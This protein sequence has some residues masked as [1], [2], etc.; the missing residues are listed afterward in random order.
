[1]SA[2]SFSRKRPRLQKGGASSSQPR[3][4]TASAYG[5]C[6]V[7]DRD[8]PLY[9]MNEHLDECFAEPSSEPASSSAAALLGMGF[10]AP[11]VEVA[12]HEAGN[13]TGAALENLLTTA[14]GA[15]AAAHAEAPTPTPQDVPTLQD[16][17]P[18]Q[19]AT[20]PAATIPSQGGGRLWTVGHSNRAQEALLTLLAQHEI[21]TLIDVRT[22]PLS[23]R[24]P[25]FNQHTLKGACESRGVRYEHH[26]QHLGGRFVAGG[27]EGNLSS[28]A[29]SRALAA[30]AKRCA[31]G[32]ERLA[33]MCSEASWHSCH[34]KALARELVR[35]HRCAVLHIT[36][37]GVERHPAPIEMRAAAVP[38]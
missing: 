21:T 36:D 13:D 26:G 28:E 8:V 38:G 19:G 5:R 17:L 20:A 15:D 11:A 16:S 18:L 2:S 22:V 25:H 32:E 12:L 33:L 4:A 6:P 7:C 24:L 35:R 23:A 14:A 37:R 3:R 10:A 30:L 27:V 29:G 31:R 9:R 34:R 1:M